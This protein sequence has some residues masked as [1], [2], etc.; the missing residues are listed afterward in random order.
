MPTFMPHFDPVVVFFADMPFITWPVFFHYEGMDSLCQANNQCATYIAMLCINVTFVVIS[1][2]TLAL[3]M[4]PMTILKQ[5]HIYKFTHDFKWLKKTLTLWS[6]FDMFFPSHT[7]DYYHHSIHRPMHSLHH[8]F[9]NPLCYLLHHACSSCQLIPDFIDSEGSIQLVDRGK[10][11]SVTQIMLPPFH[12]IHFDLISQLYTCLSQKTNEIYLSELCPKF[13][14][15]FLKI[16]SPCGC[17]PEQRF[18]LHQLLFQHHCVCLP[19]H[20]LHCSHQVRFT[21]QLCWQDQW[22]N[23]LLITYH[24]VFAICNRD[25]DNAKSLIFLKMMKTFC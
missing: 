10:I 21:W 12:H 25:V 5:K 4:S 19:I 7:R 2:P 22:F 8:C 14:N 13:Q 24:Q 9:Q 1:S 6:L 3:F 15:Q 11:H 17:L 18:S 20:F 16:F 23:H